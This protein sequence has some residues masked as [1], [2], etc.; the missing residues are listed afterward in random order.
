MY[1]RFI[2][3]IIYTYIYIYIYVIAVIYSCFRALSLL[4]SFRQVFLKP[5]GTFRDAGFERLTYGCYLRDRPAEHVAPLTVPTYGPNCGPHE[6]RLM[7]IH[8]ASS[9]PRDA[10]GNGHSEAHPLTLAGFEA[11]LHGSDLGPIREPTWALGQKCYVSFRAPSGKLP[12]TFRRFYLRSW[13]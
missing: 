11:R 10:E 6:R 2:Q 7:Y 8:P 1:N 4:L 5:S 3:H 13:N 12:A 9:K